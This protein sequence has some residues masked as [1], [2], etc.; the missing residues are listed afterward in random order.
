MNKLKLR[1][2]LIMGSFFLIA[3][4]GCSVFQSSDVFECRLVELRE[5]PTS[6]Y[7]DA[8]IRVERIDLIQPLKSRFYLTT[9]SILLELV[10]ARYTE[11]GESEDRLEVG[12]TF[13]VPLQKPDWKLFILEENDIYVVLYRTRI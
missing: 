7:Y 11:D 4:T 5:N 9:P 2:I 1:T 13:I 6:Q 12:D 3:Y 10:N 8:V